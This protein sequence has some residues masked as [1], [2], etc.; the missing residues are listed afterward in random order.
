MSTTVE[1]LKSQI[2]NLSKDERAELA[3]YLL[4]ALEPESEE[5]AWK[6]EMVR[7][8]EEL[9]TGKVQGIPAEQAMA[10]LRELLG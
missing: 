9:R 8:V 3:F 6:Q 5:E 2:D 7:R 10:E 1:T 4:S